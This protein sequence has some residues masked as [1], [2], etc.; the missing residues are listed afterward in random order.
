MAF[1]FPKPNEVLGG[2]TGIFTGLNTERLLRGEQIFLE[3]ATEA[4]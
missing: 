3:T 4:R 2:S 1:V